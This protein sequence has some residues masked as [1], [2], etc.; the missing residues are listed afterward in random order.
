M[1]EQIAMEVLLKFVGKV[2]DSDPDWYGLMSDVE[3]KHVK[4][5]DYFQPFDYEDDYIKFFVVDSQHIDITIKS[6][7][8]DSH[9]W[10]GTSCLP[11]RCKVVK[12]LDRNLLALLYASLPH[13]VIYTLLEK[14]SK[15]V[16]VPKRQLRLFADAL[17]ADLAK[18][19]G[20]SDWFADAIH[21]FVAKFG[22]VFHEVMRFL[23]VVGLVGLLAGCAY[24]HVLD[25]DYEPPTVIYN[26]TVSD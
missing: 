12:L 10:D 6:F 21:W 13:D 4:C 3:Y 2:I 24:Q 9:M 22:G 16:G 14:I 20:A 8:P 25:E 18:A 19:Y 17:L 11:D 5:S 23:A 7:P 26:C 1:T 15:A